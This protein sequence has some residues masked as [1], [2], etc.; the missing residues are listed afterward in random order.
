MVSRYL[1][2][3]SGA[4]F[5]FH[6]AFLAPEINIAKSDEFAVVSSN[7][8]NVAIVSESAWLSLLWRSRNVFFKTFN[9]NFIMLFPVNPRKQ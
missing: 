8:C 9:F 6:N 4:G 1:A 2:S 3:I 5:S 7:V